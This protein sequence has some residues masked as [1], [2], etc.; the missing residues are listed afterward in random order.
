MS[1][2]QISFGSP[3]AFN[4]VVEIPKGSS[5]KYEYD[6]ALDV[7]KL[8]WVFSG[9]FHFPLDYGY[10]PQTRGGDGDHL[11]AFIITSYP[12]AVGTIAECRPIGMI[13]LLD[14]GEEDN[15]IIAVPL[16]DPQTQHIGS[17]KDF[18]DDYEEIFQTFFKEL[19]KQKSKTVE[20]KGFFDAERARE[21][22]VKAHEEY[23]P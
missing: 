8:D 3:E 7:I 21:E 17:L 2:K 12:L 20:L 15:K 22:I 1:F 23:E 5:N 19:G 10:V 13:E 4:I 16:A 6:E 14:R 11:D 9:N 18:P